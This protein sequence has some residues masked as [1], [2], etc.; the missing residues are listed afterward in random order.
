M[1]QGWGVRREYSRLSWVLC[2]ASFSE[3]TL[4]KEKQAAYTS[5]TSLLLDANGKVKFGSCRPCLRPIHISFICLLRPQYLKS[6][7]WTSSNG[8]TWE[9][10]RNAFSQDLGQTCRGRGCILTSFPGDSCIHIIE[11]KVFCV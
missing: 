3:D 1:R 10:V 5:E 9:P 11:A 7:L 8:N 2:T 6:G 4:K